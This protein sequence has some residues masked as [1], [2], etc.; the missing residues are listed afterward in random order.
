MALLGFHFFFFFPSMVRCVRV[1][2]FF[3][4]SCVLCAPSYVFNSS[5]AHTHGWEYIYPFYPFSKMSLDGWLR[6]I[7]KTLFFSLFLVFF[8]SPSHSLARRRCRSHIQCV[9]VHW[10]NQ[11]E[12]KKI[13]FETWFIKIEC[14]QYFLETIF[15]PSVRPFARSFVRSFISFH[16]LRCIH[17]IAVMK[18]KKRIERNKKKPLRIY[19]YSEWGQIIQIK[20]VCKQQIQCAADQM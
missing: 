8:G 17:S 1:Y 6:N 4:L 12:E 13:A 10:T 16:L 20:I 5:N 9:Y 14:T 3:A 2:A 18:G 15:F 7:L 11:N 19:L